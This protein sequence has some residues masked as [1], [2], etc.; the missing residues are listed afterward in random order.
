M[1]G[2]IT[3]EDAR[4]R[5][6]EHHGYLATI[7]SVEENA[8]VSALVGDQE[9]FWVRDA[10]GG[11]NNGPW[12]GGTDAPGAWTWVT[13]EPFAFTNWSPGAPDGGT[14]EDCLHFAG[15]V[16][17]PP[18]SLWNDAPCGGFEAHPLACD[19]E[20]TTL[21]PAPGPSAYVVE[22]DAGPAEAPDAD[23][24]GLADGEDA[25]PRSDLSVTVVI[26]GCDSGVR[27]TV[28]ANGCTV[29]DLLAGCA[30]GAR[31]HGTFVSCMSHVAHGLVAEGTLTAQERGAF[32]RRAA[33]ADIP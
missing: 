22:Y 16:G 21:G 15:A 10:C 28:F 29:R 9:R 14:R 32:L 24:D 19:P 23:G 30:P 1:P 18:G 8:F 12:I 3:W 33:Q 2:G 25:C 5:A 4:A 6:Q 20:A 11:G 26:G 31:N 17:D 27:N 13:G 7:A